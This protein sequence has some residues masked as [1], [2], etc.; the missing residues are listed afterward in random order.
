M[1]LHNPSIESQLHDLFIS[2]GQIASAGDIAEL[3][4]QFESFHGVHLSDIEITVAARNAG[5]SFVDSMVSN[6]YDTEEEGHVDIE[7]LETRVAYWEAMRPSTIRRKHIE[8]I[9]AKP[10]TVILHTHP[11]KTSYHDNM[12]WVKSL[13]KG[14]CVSP[15][16]VIALIQA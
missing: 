10:E 3:V 9:L 11:G 1:S 7:P 14:V 16:Q 8:T 13:E 2:Q 5:E 15:G 6:E 4:L 12:E